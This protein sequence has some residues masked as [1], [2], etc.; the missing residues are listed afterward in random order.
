LDGVANHIQLPDLNMSISGEVLSEAY[1]TMYRVRKLSD[2]VDKDQAALRFVHSFPKGH[3][4][5]QVAAGMLLIK[6]DYIFPYYRDTALL[7]GAGFNIADMLMQLYSRSGDPF[8]GGTSYFNHISYNGDDLPKV[9]LQSSA[10]GMQAIPAVSL[11]QGVNHMIN[12]NLRDPDP[13]LSLC[14]LGEG[15]LSSGEVSEAVQMA[16]FKKLPV[17][18]LVQ[19]NGWV[20]SSTKKETVSRVSMNFYKDVKGLDH[21]RV[22][23]W[24]FE[25]C[26]IKLKKAFQRCREE[27]RP[28]IIHASVK[29]LGH[30]TSKVKHQSY[31]QSNDVND[32]YSKYD[33]LTHLEDK[34]IVHSIGDSE[35]ND[36]R[37]SI[38]SQLDSILKEIR[39]MSEDILRIPEIYAPNDQ[40][41][42]IGVRA[43][44]DGVEVQMAEA[45]GKAIH[46]IMENHPE[47]VYQG[48]DIGS[49]LGGV[50]RESYGLAN[51][52]G[53][54]R[55]MN[56]SIQE[57]YIVGSCSGLSAAGCLPISIIQFADYFM[58]GINQLFTEISKS[59]FLTDGKWPVRCLIRIPVGHYSGAG[60]YHAAC[61]ESIL[62][63]I[64]GVKVIFPSNAADMKGLLKAAFHDPGPVISLEHKGLYWSVDQ[65][66][67]TARTI[68]PDKDYMIP[69]GRGRIV[70]NASEEAVDLGRS[71]VI[72]TYGMGVHWALKAAQTFNDQIEI[73][74]LRSL[75][76]IDF[77]LVTERVRLHGKC[78]L[79]TEEPATNSFCAGLAGRIQEEMF[80]YL[81]APVMISGSEEVPA[82]PINPALEKAVLN[83]VDKV[84]ALIKRLLSY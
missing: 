28:L 7:H 54:D 30:H 57:A 53:K 68:M 63:N 83:N 8:S 35:L 1:K 65:H 24:D 10:T 19:D 14:S 64:K 3:E 38:D 78:L 45:A 81:D 46:E 42:E 27:S 12:S 72:V 40:I 55:V 16:V 47:A 11:A 66:T 73:V 82:V 67:E 29:L 41:R 79:V 20:I 49:R 25:K 5:I 74:D 26:Y 62:L 51:A 56:M 44:E 9:P 77:D 58:L 70:R 6:S 2:L 80:T 48:Q 60:P 18:F 59:Y 75:E 22:S 23:G 17:V 34:L 76:P 84:E 50:F 33:P 39:S 43:P 15:A 31:R 36:I 71:A 69:L 32:M 37:N 52:F 21:I 13:F 61:I 4:A